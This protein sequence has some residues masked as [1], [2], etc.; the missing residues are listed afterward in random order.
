MSGSNGRAAACVVLAAAMLAA[1]AA[2]VAADGIEGLLRRSADDLLKKATQPKPR[3]TPAVVSA[4]G[5]GPASPIVG[6]PL[7]AAPPVAWA[8]KLGF[9]DWSDLAFANGLVLGSNATGKGSVFAVDAANGKLRWRAADGNTTSVAPVADGTHAYFALGRP[10]TLAAFRLDTGK[11]AWSKPFAFVDDGQPVIADG[12]LIVQGEDG[13]LY[14]F[15]PATGAERWKTQ[16][17]RRTNWCGA[18]RAAAAGR[19]SA[20]CSSMATSTA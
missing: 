15:D 3:T 13:F 18:G 14:A 8:A 17:A 20:S 1:S 6:A 9:R 5:T 16:Y 19:C 4:T 11:L 12:L 10:P 7:G 2:P